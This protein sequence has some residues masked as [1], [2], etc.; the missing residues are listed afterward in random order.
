M[1][2]V[3]LQDAWFAALC[4][5]PAKGRIWLI[6][7]AATGC[8]AS[9]FSIHASGIC[10][11]F[12]LHHRLDELSISVNNDLGRVNKKL[13]GRTFKWFGILTLAQK[14]DGL[15]FFKGTEMGVHYL[16]AW[17]SIHPQKSPCLFFGSTSPYPKKMAP[18]FLEISL[19]I[20]AWKFKFLSSCDWVVQGPSIDGMAASGSRVTWSLRKFTRS[21]LTKLPGNKNGLEL[22]EILMSYV[23]FLNKSISVH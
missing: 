8:L 16:Q 14:R 17:P 21:D 1:K 4:S 22:R 2:S 12:S 13:L 3:K 18:F 9:P 10:Q 11:V 23:V 20:P 19:V 7:Q 5:I 6:Q 15:I